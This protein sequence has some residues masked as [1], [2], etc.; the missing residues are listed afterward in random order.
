[1]VRVPLALT[2][3]LVNVE[4]GMLVSER[5]YRGVFSMPAPLQLLLSSE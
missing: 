2:L 5:F 4:R 3:K 1:L